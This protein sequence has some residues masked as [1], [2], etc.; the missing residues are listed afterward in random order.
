MGAF[1]GTFLKKKK[2]HFVF[3]APPK[4]MP[5]LA[6]ANENIFFIKTQGTRLRMIAT[7]DRGLE[8]AQIFV[9]W[10]SFMSR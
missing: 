2:K 3:F 7:L 4:Q 5:F 10:P 6:I 9:G 1:W 8:Y